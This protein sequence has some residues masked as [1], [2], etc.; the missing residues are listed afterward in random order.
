[1]DPTAA[2]AVMRDTGHTLDVRA[3]AALDLLAWMAK[4]GFCP[5]EPDEVRGRTGS[6]VQADIV[7]EA[8]AI[9]TGLLDTMELV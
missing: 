9:V 6:R 2:L 3:I 4:G 5:V 7:D 8:K 1:M